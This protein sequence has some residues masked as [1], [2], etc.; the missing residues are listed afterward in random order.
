MGVNVDVKEFMQ[1]FE[2]NLS[3]NLS[4][5]GSSQ[6]VANCKVNIG[7]IIFQSNVNC[8][9]NITNNCVASADVSVS[10]VI[11]ALSDAFNSMSSTQK[12]SIAGFT[13]GINVGVSSTA[14]TFIQN[15]TNTINQS[16]SASAV[17][18]SEF[19]LGTL[20]FGSCKNYFGTTTINFINTGQARGNCAM[21]L[22][23]DLQLQ[24]NNSNTGVQ[25]SVFSG[26]GSI[27][28]A[29]GNLLGQY[30]KFIIGFIAILL[31]TPIIYLIVK[32]FKKNKPAIGDNNSAVIFESPFIKEL[33][34]KSLNNE[35]L[36]WSLYSKFL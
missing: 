7:S 27:L 32:L 12:T 10:A 29:F 11:N 13:G 33:A 35:P 20:S 21:K 15:M 30:A 24:S 18:N 5:S 23:S 4:Q 2:S 9:V 16:C 34:F 22:V 8:S 19:N 14:Q 17:A 31:F 6:A 26:F 28:T 3:N 1:K 25:D 36:H